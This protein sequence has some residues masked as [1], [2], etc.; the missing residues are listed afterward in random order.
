MKCP[1]CDEIIS[2]KAIV[3]AFCQRDL[4]LFSP[5]FERLSRTEKQVRDLK[6]NI[7]SHGLQPT[8]MAPTIALFSSILMAFLFTWIDWQPIAGKQY[9]DWLLQSLAVA[10]PFIAAFGLGTFSPGA[11]RSVYV[12]LGIIA[13]CAG[14][15]QML[16]LYAIGRAHDAIVLADKTKS[17]YVMA[18]PSRWYL[19]LLIY[20]VSGG[21][22]FLSGGVIGERVR[23][24]YRPRNRRDKLR[25]DSNSETQPSSWLRTL[26]PYL[27]LVLGTL[28][29]A[30]AKYAEPVKNGLANTSHQ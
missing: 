7:P 21:L 10:S 2:S 29:S 14:F 22:L 16:F 1:Y 18:H 30:I 5:I 17:V 15:V 19:S 3:C 11:Q 13:G 24:W 6:R 26:Q 23:K 8:D 28:L 12:L 20:P 4:A 25:N 27:L 9:D